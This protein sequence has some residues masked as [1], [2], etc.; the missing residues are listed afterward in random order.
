VRTA[1]DYK[2]IL[3]VIRQRIPESKAIMIIDDNGEIIENF[4]TDS[5]SDM[6]NENNAKYLAA[7]ISIRFH[8]ADFHKT[9]GDLMTTTDL[10]K[11]HILF[12]IRL[13]VRGL[14]LILCS[15]KHYPNNIDDLVSKE[16]EIEFRSS[17]S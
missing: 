9:F 3:N 7:L 8:F 17:Y 13:G 10:F 12:E 14:L 16:L 5:Y 11:D 4:V 15:N 6:I 1:L 2:R